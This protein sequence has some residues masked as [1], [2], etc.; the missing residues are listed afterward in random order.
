MGPIIA[1]L[2]RL[3]AVERELATVRRRLD[4]RRNAVAAQ[5]RK[6]DELGATCQE[7]QQKSKLRR[8]DADLLGVDLRQREEQVSKFRAALNTAKT[9]KEYAA[10][11]TQINS[12]KA[13]NAKL[14]EEVLK[15][16]QDSDTAVAEAEQAQ[17]GIEAEVQKLQEVSQTSQQE[18]SRLE[19]MLKELTTR[20]TEAAAAVP[21]RELGLFNRIAA[22]YDGEAMAAIEV[23]GKKPPYEY[24]CGG[25]FMS[26]NAEHANALRVH[27]AVRTCDNCQRILYLEPQSEHSSV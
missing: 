20:R 24:I 2:L 7:R 19:G 23:H 21:P 1:A 6:V 15:V 16:M 22:N 25:C 18:I 26:L 9:N 11:L 17:K 5:Q 8:K 10:I 12:L 4:S 3:Q 27:D 14:E 13:D